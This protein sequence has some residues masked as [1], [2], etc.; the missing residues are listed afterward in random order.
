VH[1][2]NL[3]KTQKRNKT[4]PVKQSSSGR[5]QS[6]GRGK[7]AARPVVEE[8][9]NGDDEEG[10]EGVEEHDEEDDEAENEDHEDR[11]EGDGEHED[12]DHEDDHDEVP[13]FRQTGYHNFVMGGKLTYLTRV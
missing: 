2:I 13:K 7:P 5:G 11:D 3:D 8:E 1:T 12:E 4:E 9:H 10:N 6:V